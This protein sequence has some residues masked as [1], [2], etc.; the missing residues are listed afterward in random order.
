MQ[1]VGVGVGLQAWR[2][3][4][5]VQ[6]QAKWMGRQ[7]LFVHQL[8]VDLRRVVVRNHERE[9]L[10]PLRVLAVVDGL[11]PVLPVS[12]PDLHVWVRLPKELHIV[13]ALGLHHS[14]IQP[15]HGKALQNE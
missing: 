8:E 4:A 6:V 15:P 14:D 9:V 1:L 2:S 12:A 5:R 13:Q 7:C 11:R 3:A 10:I